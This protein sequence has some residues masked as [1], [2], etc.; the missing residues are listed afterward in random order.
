MHYWWLRIPAIMFST[1]HILIPTD[2]VRCLLRAVWR[3]RDQSGLIRDRGEMETGARLSQ[4]SQCLSHAKLWGN[5][6]LMIIT[7]ICLWL[8]KM[9]FNIANFYIERAWTRIDG[10]LSFFVI[11]WLSWILRDCRLVSPGKWHLPR[12]VG[13]RPICQA[14]DWA[15]TR[16]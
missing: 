12:S 6:S 3:G 1:L 2:N 8:W 7:N 15:R 4:L 16:P 5:R 13:E 10:L 14:K 11:L 9:S